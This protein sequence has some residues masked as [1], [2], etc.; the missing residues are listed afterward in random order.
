MRQLLPEIA[1]L[2]AGLVGIQALRMGEVTAHVIHAPPNKTSNRE[3]QRMA[4]SCAR[5]EVKHFQR[6]CGKVTGNAIISAAKPNGFKL[7]IC[8]LS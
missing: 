2:R 5:S 4:E 1:Q 7:S 3:W 8:L 6:A